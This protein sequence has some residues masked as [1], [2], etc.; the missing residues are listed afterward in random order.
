[1]LVQSLNQM[2]LGLIVHYIIANSSV[3]ENNQHSNAHICL[4]T[5]K[6]IKYPMFQIQ[7]IDTYNV[8]LFSNSLK[9][10]KILSKKSD[11]FFRNQMKKMFRVG[12]TNRYGRVTETRH[13]F[14]FALSIVLPCK[15]FGVEIILNAILFIKRNGGGMVVD[16]TTYGI[17]RDVTAQVRVAKETG[18]HVVAGA[19]TFSWQHN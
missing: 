3:S 5:K 18:V 7:I 12:Q 1:M 13:V 11:H 10:S 16:N 8:L 6:K 15:N 9:F 4:P 19:G 2:V 17:K 14:L